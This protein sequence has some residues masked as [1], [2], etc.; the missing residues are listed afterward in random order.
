MEPDETTVSGRI[1]AEFEDD[2]SDFLAGEPEF[3]S[4]SPAAPP[5]PSTSSTPVSDVAPGK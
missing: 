5:V 4:T 3:V 2:A 1:V